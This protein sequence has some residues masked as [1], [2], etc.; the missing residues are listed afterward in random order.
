MPTIKSVAAITARCSSA[1]DPNPWAIHVA[2]IRAAHH[3][4]DER[5][6]ATQQQ[7]VL[8]AKARAHAIE[9]GS[10]SPMK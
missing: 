10:R 1:S 6:H 4:A 2:T 3:Q 8:E 7:A 5:E 9:P